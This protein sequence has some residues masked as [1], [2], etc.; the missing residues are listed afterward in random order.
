M[1]HTDR[2]RSGIYRAPQEGA[3]LPPGRIIGFLPAGGPGGGLP[4]EGGLDDPI[5]DKI[6]VESFRADPPSIV[7]CTK[8]FTTLSWKIK[9]PNDPRA[10]NLRFG[11]T[12]NLPA[13]GTD[14]PSIGNLE[15]EGAVMA[16]PLSTVTINLF[17]YFRDRPNLIAL[18][19]GDN[20]PGVTVTVTENPRC[21]ILPVTESLAKAQVQRALTSFL[22]NSGFQ[23]K[24]LNVRIDDV[25]GL[26]L[27]IELVHPT[28][29]GDID[30]S[31]HAEVVLF[32][33]D[34]RA[35]A[36]L[37]NFSK[38]VDLP[39]F[40]D[41]ASLGLDEIAEAIINSSGDNAIGE[42][43]RK[44]IEDGINGNIPSGLCLCRLK[45]LPHELD[46]KVCPLDQ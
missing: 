37:L 8:Q 1:E 31:I 2:E 10:P 30:V 28:F 17:A 11:I 3:V 13:P 24:S 45:F 43:I 40:L 21:I 14:F 9:L 19:D 44:E 6:K 41:I 42:Q 12:A 5:W 34:C 39:L 32:A 4:G 27:D 38:D 35:S 7:E 18:I 33:Q 29:F 16:R 15:P 23:Q 20:P 22:A 36:S 25:H 26:V 46:V